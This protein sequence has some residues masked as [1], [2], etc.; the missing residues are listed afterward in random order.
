MRGPNFSRSLLL[1]LLRTVGTGTEHAGARSYWR[2]QRC[3]SRVSIEWCPDRF[4]ND[5]ELPPCD[6]R[7]VKR[8]WQSPREAYAQVRF[9]ALLAKIGWCM[10]MAYEGQ[11]FEGFWPNST[12]LQVPRRVRLGGTSKQQ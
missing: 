6:G 2:S 12:G 4:S 5:I 11:R 1:K 3:R 9:V 8:F 10:P 7:L